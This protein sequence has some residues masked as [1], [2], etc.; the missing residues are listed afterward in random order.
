MRLG[1]VRT[2]LVVGLVLTACTGGGAPEILTEADPV[3]VAAI[4][5]L[6]TGAG[7]AE[8][9][10]VLEAASTFPTDAEQLAAVAVVGGTG[11]LAEATLV[12]RWSVATGTGE[13]DA[14]FTHEILVRPGDRA[15]SIGV[16]NGELLPGSYVIEAVLGEEVARVDLMVLPAEAGTALGTLGGV[17]LG[18]VM[19]LGRV[20]TQA[21]PS[22]GPAPPDAGDSGAI[23]ADT[24]G[25]DAGGGGCAPTLQTSGDPYVI[26]NTTG[27]GGDSLV[28]AAGPDGGPLTPFDRFDGDTFRFWNV[29]PCRV[30]ASDEPGATIVYALEAARGPH[31]GT[32]VDATTTI[33][34][35]DSAPSLWVDARPPV[36]R[37]ALGGTT[38]EITIK[39][40]DAHTNLS[41]GTGISLI[42]AVDGSGAVLIDQ[43]FERGEPCDRSRFERT[44]TVSSPVPPDGPAT[45]LVTVTI[46]DFAGHEV[47]Q[48]F[49]WPTRV[50][51]G[52]LLVART[53]ETVPGNS[54]RAV[55]HATFQIELAR[56]GP[57]EGSGIAE[58]FSGP[59]CDLGYSAAGPVEF[60]FLWV[61]GFD[62][63]RFSL[64]FQPLGGG[65]GG[66]D[67]GFHLMYYPTPAPFV[68]PFDGY[69]GTIDISL[70]NAGAE[71][72]AGGGGAAS[73]DG[74]I[75][76]HI[77]ESLE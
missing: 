70:S 45:H 71:E 24:G 44:V 52:G 23:P 12:M 67:G 1:G 47:T 16:S 56:I 7:V 54:C 61:G 58:P 63:E 62:G 9:G 49:T 77:E 14:L 8:D 64:E 46:A 19:G 41:G 75:E 57:V 42:R 27:C 17:G 13:L 22:E 4:V 59:R 40:S 37:L 29:D 48:A 34:E 11:D 10:S 28:G 6:A 68:I 66:F 33:G 18:S 72:L 2:L 39:A 20:V 31:A 36:G 30:G 21:D 38:I 50:Q 73:L 74:W 32:R 43:A 65:P 35:D 5:A 76:L 69:H 26:V 3:P 15:Y 55:W 51:L 53:T 60:P 25:P